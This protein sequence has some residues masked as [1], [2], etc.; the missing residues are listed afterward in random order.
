MEKSP[1]IYR[2]EAAA[3]LAARDALLSAS[4]RGPSHIALP[5]ARFAIGAEYPLVLRGGEF[6]RCLAL[7]Q[8]RVA[9]HANFWPRAFVSSTGVTLPVALV[10]NVATDA[11]LRGRGLM[12][13]LFEELCGEARRAGLRALLLWSDLQEFYQK[14]GFQATGRELRVTAKVE[15]LPRGAG[16]CAAIGALDELKA[17][18]L[19][20][21]RPRIPWT[22]KRNAREFAEQ[23]TIPGMHGLAS[24]EG[25]GVMG[26]G[27]DMQGVVHEWGGKT[28][29]AALAVARALGEAA[30][31]E[32][33]VIL[34]PGT[35]E[36]EMRDALAGVAESV[37]EHAMAWVLPL[38]GDVREL[39]RA[40]VWGLDSI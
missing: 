29:A 23:L 27:H 5:G 28:P 4:L 6:S 39:E 31:Y 19:L 37:E 8:T 34:A 2:P 1:V 14:L 26:R 17:Q 7:G 13:T 22:L 18:R 15:R 12:S 20:A 40:F 32:Q 38:G 16:A 3:D 21:Q 9:A 36:R 30:G 10:G 11:S 24:A 25:W 35:V 33:L